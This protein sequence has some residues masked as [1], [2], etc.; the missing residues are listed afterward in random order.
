MKAEA[1]VFDMDG[2]LIDS[3]V[4]WREVREEFAT[5]IGLVWDERD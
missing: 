4:L 5:D 1:V 3:E 2:V